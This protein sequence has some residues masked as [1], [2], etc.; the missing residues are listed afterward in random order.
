MKTRFK[1]IGKNILIVLLF[2]SLLLLTL[3][4]LPT[5]SVSAIPWLSQ[6]LQPMGPLLGLSEAELTYVAQADPV[7]E[8]AKPVAISIHHDAGRHSVQW[9]HASLD[10]AFSVF[11]PILSQAMDHAETFRPASSYEVQAALSGSSVY[12]QYSSPLPAELICSW[13]GSRTE[14]PCDTLQACILSARS[15][16]L[17]LLV[18][19]EEDYICSTSL[20]SGL[21]LPLLETYVPDGSQF[22]YETQ[23]RL[24]DLSL[25]PAENSVPGATVS[26]LAGRDVEI[27]ATTLGFN[28]YAET[29]YTDDRGTDCFT[30]TGASLQISTDGLVFLQEENARFTARSTQ[31]ED[32]A[33]AA[34]RLADTITGSLSDN[35]RLYLTQMEQYANVT[36]CKFDYFYSGIRV[37]LAEPAAVISFSGTAVT[38]ARIQLYSFAAS[39]KTLY[40]LPVPQ[41]DAVLTPGTRLELAYHPGSDGKL[42][43]GWCR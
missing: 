24:D 34:R 3:I 1:E 5:R 41:A 14:L 4:A 10:A 37:R 22:A 12:V 6:L 31:T 23:Y 43:V 19:G 16:T 40:P 20:S 29:R 15:N 11:S 42:T 17:S 2:C 30:E 9:D 18:L 25:L 21:L 35:T 38:Q 13:L 27:L 33:E 26:T 36:V 39:G 8:G 28:P 7:P 32:L